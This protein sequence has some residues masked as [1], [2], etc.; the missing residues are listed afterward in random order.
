[1]LDEPDLLLNL[2]RMRS[3]SAP[4][5]E[6]SVNVAVLMVG[7]SAALG[8]SREKIL[9]AGI[10]GMLHDIGMT[11]LPEEL[12][13]RRLSCTRQELEIIKRHPSIGLDII[14]SNLKKMA[15][16]VRK[17]IGQHHERLNGS[18]YPS[19]LRGKQIDEL[20]MICAVADMYD[21]LTTTGI[22][23]RT[24]IPQEALALI[25]QGADD[26]YPRSMVEHFTKLLGIYPVGS[27]VKLDTGEMGTVVKN[28]RQR[29]LTPVVKVLFDKLGRQL[30]TPYLNDLS[31][32]SDIPDG[33]G[34]RVT[35]SL[36]PHSFNITADDFVSG[37]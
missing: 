25:F 9:D 20:A 24:C 6:H 19:G 12:L 23:T 14:D 22:P 15:P 26:E 10:G 35:A 28:N 4:T 3:T 33:L 8:F 7:F 16:V 2:S 29:L 18:G 21:S 27:F 30:E 32:T 5:Y 37:I 1:M 13:H 17:V 31:V 34:M 36:D 11:R